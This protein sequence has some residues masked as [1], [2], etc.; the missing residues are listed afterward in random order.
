MEQ[1][2]K[3][4]E[5]FYGLNDLR[6]TYVDI[7]MEIRFTLLEGRVHRTN[8][9]LTGKPNP[10]ITWSMLGSVKSETLGF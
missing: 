4:L 1:M 8:D 10:R 3:V 2:D 9:L 5:N 6:T 7:V